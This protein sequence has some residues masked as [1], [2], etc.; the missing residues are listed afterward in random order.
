MPSG[1]TDILFGGSTML[2]GRRTECELLDSLVA[3]VRGGRSG[4]LV[5]RAEP[6]IGKTALL[7]YVVDGASGCRDVRD[8]V[9]VRSPDAGSVT[10]SLGGLAGMPTGR[11]G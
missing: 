3:G 9:G 4:V 7:R 6:G 11:A 2:R 1:P 8:R 5:L 10:G